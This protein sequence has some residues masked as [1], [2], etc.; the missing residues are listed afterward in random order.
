MTS[1]VD[2]GRAGTPLLGSW[3]EGSVSAEFERAAIIDRVIAGMDRK[4]SLGGWCGGIVPY[5][6]QSRLGEVDYLPGE[7]GV[8]VLIV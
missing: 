2:I 8:P 3:S 5:G 4:A 1:A 7:F 6:S